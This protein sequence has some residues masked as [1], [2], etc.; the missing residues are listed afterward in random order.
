VRAP[1]HLIRALGAAFLALWIAGCAA[2]PERC[3]A[4]AHGSTSAPSAGAQCSFQF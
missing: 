2:S 3:G 1:L 4:H